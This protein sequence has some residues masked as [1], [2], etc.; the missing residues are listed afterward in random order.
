M[1]TLRIGTYDGA[2]TVFMEEVFDDETWLLTRLEVDSVS[3]GLQVVEGESDGVALGP[4]IDL[5]NATGSQPLR[6]MRMFADVEEGCAV[7]GRLRSAP[8][9]EDLPL[10]NSPIVA[11]PWLPWL[12][13]FRPD[14][15]FEAAGLVARDDLLTQYLN[16][17]YTPG[18]CVQFEFQMYD[19]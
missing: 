14:P 1:P 18:P 16:L 19:E 7:V 9:V 6:A 11:Y 5:T 3:G 12:N 10:D 13:I 4:A 2:E 15:E 17:G 8:T